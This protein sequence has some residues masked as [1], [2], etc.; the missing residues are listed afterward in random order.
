MNTKNASDQLQRQW[1]MEERLRII[2]ARLDDLEKQAP[3]T[4]KTTE[5]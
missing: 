3:K 2:E 4:D 1:E 5:V